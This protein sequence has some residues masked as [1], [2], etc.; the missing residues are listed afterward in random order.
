MQILAVK[1]GRR[2]TDKRQACIQ[3]G[4][5]HDVRGLAVVEAEGAIQ[6]LRRPLGHDAPVTAVIRGVVVTAAQGDLLRHVSDRVRVNRGQNHRHIAIAEQ[7]ALCALTDHIGTGVVSAGFRQACRVPVEEVLGAEGQLRIEVEGG[8]NLVAWQEQFLGLGARRGSGLGQIE[9]GL[10]VAQRVRGTEE[11]LAPEYVV[12]ASF[13]PQQR[14]VADLGVVEQ[15]GIE[16]FTGRAV[17]V[18]LG[19]VTQMTA[20]KAPA[21]ALA[22]PSAWVM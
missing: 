13:Y 3:G 15:E 17:V 22:G 21:A 18:T 12:L 20:A 9:A 5:R 6:P 4:L 8:G 10:T 16:D 11:G 1:Y 14:V 2:N 7:Q 19:V